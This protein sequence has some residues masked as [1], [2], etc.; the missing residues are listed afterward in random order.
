MCREISAR[1]TETTVSQ[2][3]TYGRVKGTFTDNHRIL[4]ASVKM[5]ICN[6]V[7]MIISYTQETVEGYRNNP[8]FFSRI[9]ENIKYLGKHRRDSKYIHP[10]HKGQASRNRH[11][12]T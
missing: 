2:K 3:L 4:V 1:L 12:H 11:L 9:E 6:N 10:Q 5:L 8:H 7:A